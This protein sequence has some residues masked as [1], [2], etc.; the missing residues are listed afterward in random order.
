MSFT[1]VDFPHIADDA[2]CHTLSEY[3]APFHQSQLYDELYRV[4]IL[5]ACVQHPSNIKAN[6]RSYIRCFATVN[7]CSQCYTSHLVHN[8][9][10]IRY[11]GVSLC[12]SVVTHLEK[13]STYIKL[14]FPECHSLVHLT[15]CCNCS[16]PEQLVFCVDV[17]IFF[18][19]FCCCVFC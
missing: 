11:A 5:Y 4:L 7:I 2:R 1:R 19:S 18:F 10:S 13:T 16:T 8:Q 14:E 9:E 15:N 12:N 17:C 6:G 3:S